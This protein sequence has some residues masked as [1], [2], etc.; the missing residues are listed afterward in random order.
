M[1]SEPVLIDDCLVG[2]PRDPT[3]ADC[4]QAMVCLKD[5]PD[6]LFPVVSKLA[7]Q[8]VIGPYVSGLMA[9]KD[10]IGQGDQATQQACVHLFE[11]LSRDASSHSNPDLLRWH[12]KQ[13]IRQ[14]AVSLCAVD[15]PTFKG[16]LMALYKLGAFSVFQMFW[17]DPARVVEDPPHPTSTTFGLSPDQELFL[18]SLRGTR[19]GQTPDGSYDTTLRHVQLLCAAAR[20]AQTKGLHRCITDAIIGQVEL[21]GLPGP[22]AF[23]GPARPPPP[24]RSRPGSAPTCRAGTVK[25]SASGTATC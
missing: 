2:P 1:A 11:R 21:A 15:S 3:F 18:I 14:V 10:P 5:C 8:R 23:P 20:A 9:L 6:L 24:R 4:R 19:L 16:T 17:V 13:G 22:R 7:L 25:P 12:W